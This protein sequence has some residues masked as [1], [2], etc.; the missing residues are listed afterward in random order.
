MKDDFFYLDP[1]E[2]AL[3][4]K[5]TLCTISYDESGNTLYNGKKPP[6]VQD[7]LKFI[8]PNQSVD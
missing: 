4:S 5:H 2:E 7:I 3:M 1:E 8:N 6:S